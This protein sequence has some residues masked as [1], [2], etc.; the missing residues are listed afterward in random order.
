MVEGM[1]VHL[2]KMCVG[3]DSVEELIEHR[4]RHRAMCENRG[5]PLETVHRTRNMPRRSGEVLAGGSLYWVIR[6]FIRARQRIVRLDELQDDEG[7]KRCGL[8][9]DVDVVR[10]TLQ[11]RRAH[12]GWR[13]L[14]DKDAPA[15]LPGWQ[16][17]MAEDDAPPPEMAA[18]L[19]ELGLI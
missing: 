12:Q 5:L 6:G 18:E 8:V 19:R 14:E 1:P 17:G 16:Q 3:I 9:L 15:D 11:A 2:L 7:G 4:A 13:Y 10:T